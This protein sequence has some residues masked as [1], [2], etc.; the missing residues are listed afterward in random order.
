MRIKRRPRKTCM[1]L[2]GGHLYYKRAPERPGCCEDIC[3]PIIIARPG[4]G[5]PGAFCDMD[6][7]SQY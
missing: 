6:F 5:G 1:F 7:L 4:P 3:S 2:G